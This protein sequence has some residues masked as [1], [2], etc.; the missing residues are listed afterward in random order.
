M[1]DYNDKWLLNTNLLLIMNTKFIIPVDIED[2]AK[3]YI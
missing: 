2:E 3:T 1:A